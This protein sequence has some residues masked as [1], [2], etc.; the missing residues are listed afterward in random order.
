M[1][2]YQIKMKAEHKCI[3]CGKV[4]ERTLSGKTTCNVCFE[5]Q[6]ESRI[7]HKPR[8]KRHQMVSTMD[9]LYKLARLATAEGLTYGQYV[10]KHRYDNR[11]SNANEKEIK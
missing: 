8:M 3:I 11:I 9:K 1:N 4:D 10:A 7:C 6:K 5:K 2:K